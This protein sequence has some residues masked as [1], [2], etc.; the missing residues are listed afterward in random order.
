M[1]QFESSEQRREQR[2]ERRDQRA[3]NREQR[4][5][6]REKYLHLRMFLLESSVAT[7]VVPV[8]VCGEDMCHGQPMLLQSL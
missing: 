7:R 2:A 1:F 8:R 6:S 4:A 3:E 5:E